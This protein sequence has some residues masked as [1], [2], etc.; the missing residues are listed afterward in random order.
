NVSLRLSRLGEDFLI[1]VTLV[2][3]TLLPLGFRSSLIVMI[4]IPLSL[5]MGLTVM[6]W[7][8]FSLN[9]LTIV[10]MVIALGLLVDDSIVGV[11]NIARFRRQGYS[12]VDAAIAATK[13]IW[14]AVLGATA[15]LIAAF[16]PLLVLPGGPGR[17]IRVMPATVMATIM[18]SF[19][20]SITIIPWLASRLL[21]E[22]E[23]P[24]GNRV[25]RAF[26]SGIHKTYAPLLDWALKRPRATIAAAAAVVVLSFALVPA[27]G[28]SLFPKAETPQVYVNITAPEG[29]SKIGRASCREREKD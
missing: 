24:H 5:L 21:P 18:A 11:E 25:L 23:D 10:G 20:V 15:T 3:L 19:L 27:I 17:F 1:A 8:G 2:L 14:V 13:Q 9:Q 29:A 4:S 12:R 6:H 7:T 26:D 16:V 22:H 28:F